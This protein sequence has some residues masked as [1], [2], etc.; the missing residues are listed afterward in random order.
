MAGKGAQIRD[1]RGGRVFLAGYVAL[2]LTVMLATLAPASPAEGR[3]RVNA[4]FDLRETYDNNAFLFRRSRVED[5]ITNISPMISASYRG[6]RLAIDLESGASFYIYGRNEN[7]DD[8]FFHQRFRLEYKLGPRLSLEA[9]N[10]YTYV[11]ETIGRPDDLTSNL[12]Q[13]NSWRV[14][15]IFRSDLGGRSRAEIKASYGGTN[16][17]HGDFNGGQDPDFGEARASLYLDRE[18]TER[19][20]VYTTQEFTRRDFAEVGDATFSGLLSEAG[21]R[22]RIG[23]T[24]S[25][26]LS[27]GYQWLRFDKVGT[28]SGNIIDV[29]IHYTPTFRTRFTAGYSQ[30]FTSDVLGK[31]FK[32]DR[33]SLEVERQIG[34][35]TLLQLTSFYS[36]LEL[37][38][39]SPSDDNFFGGGVRL[40]HKLRRH[41][42]LTSE[43]NW[44]QNAGA[45]NTDDYERMRGM[46]GLKYEF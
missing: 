38:K 20:L 44:W 2:V 45:L 37:R 18:L 14:G 28:E 26:D 25:V 16:Y 36:Q 12:V 33:V 30:L 17:I 7:L 1:D 34:P 19:V 6:P 9:E 40:D 31:V 23:R 15:P 13:S 24:V 43:W 27:G 4:S 10:L 32:Q 3:V 41:L 5:F 29:A 22:W 42:H 39:A 11:T 35:R 46:M 8:Q 21:L